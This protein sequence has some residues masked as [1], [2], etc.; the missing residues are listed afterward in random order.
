MYNKE[1]ALNSITLNIRGDKTTY[2]ITELGKSR[3]A[4]VF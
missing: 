4:I 2:V 3:A 1:V